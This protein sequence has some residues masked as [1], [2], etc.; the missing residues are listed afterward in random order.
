MK[1]LRLSSKPSSMREPSRPPDKP[2]SSSPRLRNTKPLKKLSLS[3]HRRNRPHSV[4]VVVLLVG[5]QPR[6]IGMKEPSIS[7]SLVLVVLFLMTCQLSLKL[8]IPLVLLLNLWTVK[9]K[10]VIQL[11]LSRMVL[12]LHIVA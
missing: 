12:I 11:V 5:Y 8:I 4:M 10:L 3:I 7:Q 2:P 9:L 6:R 1:P